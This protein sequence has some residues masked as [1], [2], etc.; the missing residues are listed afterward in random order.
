MPAGKPRM[1]EWVELFDEL[2]PEV[3]PWP[4]GC[5]GVAGLEAKIYVHSEVEVHTVCQRLF[6]KL[7]GK[8]LHS[9][10]HLFF[11]LLLC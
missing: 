5:F 7:H 2:R 10:Q 1:R 11:M 3:S 8:G 4:F 6:K 9:M